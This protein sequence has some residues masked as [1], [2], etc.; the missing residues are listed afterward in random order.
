MVKMKRVSLIDVSYRAARTFGKEFNKYLLENE[1]A[2]ELDSYNPMLSAGHPAAYRFCFGLE[3]FEKNEYDLYLISHSA[4]VNNK[5]I[6]KNAVEA[7]CHVK[8]LGPSELTPDEAGYS[9]LLKIIESVLE[10]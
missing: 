7:G 1:K 9:S 2:I 5:Y 4:G 3:H 10:S 8:H 6:M